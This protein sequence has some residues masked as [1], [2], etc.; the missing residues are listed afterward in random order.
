MAQPISVVAGEEAVGPQGTGSV[1]P[2]QP[3]SVVAGEEA[4][5]L[6][7]TPAPGGLDYV[8]TWSVANLATAVTGGR[9]RGVCH[10][11]IDRS[12]HFRSLLLPQKERSCHIHFNLQQVPNYVNVSVRS[13]FVSSFLSLVA[14]TK[15]KEDKTPSH[16]LCSAGE[17]FKWLGCTRVA[18]NRIFLSRKNQTLKAGYSSSDLQISNVL[19]FFK[20]SLNILYRTAKEKAEDKDQ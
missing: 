10:W 11:R 3:I 1:T 12:Q 5:G 17:F 16:G 8:M 6:C 9:G 13:C 7:F 20:L 14:L 15:D 4:A 2:A 19:C 18:S